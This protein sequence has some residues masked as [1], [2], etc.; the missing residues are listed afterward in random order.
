MRIDQEIF[1]HMKI[2]DVHIERVRGLGLSA[3]FLLLLPR[4]FQVFPLWSPSVTW[5]L[6]SKGRPSLLRIL[7]PT[8]RSF[9]NLMV[10]G[11]YISQRR[12]HIFMESGAFP[13]HRQAT[14]GT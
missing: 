11:F 4:L 1:R 9:G 3:N 10:S 13:V 14:A 8:N 12:K 7:P 5:M 6:A 2:P